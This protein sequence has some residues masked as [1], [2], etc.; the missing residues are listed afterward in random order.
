MRTFTIRTLAG[1]VA[2]AAAGSLAAVAITAAPA[3][4]THQTGTKSLAAVLAADGQRFDHN[5]YDYDILDAAVAAV[6]KA[7]PNS[8]VKV[9]ANGKVTLTAFLPKDYA[10]KKLVQETTGKW[11]DDEGKVF[12]A[13]A[14]ALGVGT[15]EKVLL[16]HVVPGATI[17]AATALKAGGTR[18]KTALGPTIRVRVHDGMITLKDKDPQLYDPTVRVPDINKGNRQIGHGIDRVLIPVDL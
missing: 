12:T 2:V 5:E 7:K 14:K 9:L 15:I 6:L 3:A 11:V 17:D 8:S 13:V 10:F 16:Y 4:A 1:G 18:L